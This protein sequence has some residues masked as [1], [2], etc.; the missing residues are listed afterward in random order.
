MEQMNKVI[1][2]QLEAIKLVFPLAISAVEMYD[3][4]DDFLVVEVNGEWMFRFPRNEIARKA[5][6][7][8]KAFLARFKSIS[9]LPVPDYQYDG[10]DFGGYRKIHGRL[11]TTDVFTSLSNPARDR[12]ARQMGQFLSTIHGFPIEEA[13][14]LGVTEGWG[15]FHQQAIRC[16]Q[17]EI[18]PML[19]LSARPNALACIERM[20]AEKFEP[21]VIH[22]DFALEDHVFLDEQ[23]QEL[24]GVIDFADVTINDPAHDFQNIVE[25][26][27]DDF[28]E[29]VMRHYRGRRDSTLLTR[30]KL[31]SVARP[32]FE[33]SYSLMFGFEKRFKE[34]MRYIEARFE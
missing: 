22:G 15:G 11:L 10:D 1:Q 13:R 20:M 7:V 25:Y 18:A 3:N 27:G 34:R 2:E 19:S 6:A 29:S 21:K 4:G 24:S 9:P 16:F 23:R 31:R 33:A 17:D 8:E 14:R 30:T 12:I 28:F 32:L 26:G 5:F